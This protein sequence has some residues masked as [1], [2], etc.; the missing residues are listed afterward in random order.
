[1]IFSIIKPK[2]YSEKLRCVEATWRLIRLL[3]LKISYLGVKNKL[4]Q[5]PDYPSLLSIADCLEGFNINSLGIKSTFEK[6]N[7]LPA[8]FISVHEN[9]G[10][11]YYNLVYKMEDEKFT[12]WDNKSFKRITKTKEEFIS[13]WSGKILLVETSP[14]SK[15]PLSEYKHNTL[16]QWRSRSIIGASILLSFMLIISPL[17][18]F[19]WRLDINSVIYSFYY[20]LKF[21]GLLV[22]VLLLWH[23]I[24]NHNPFLQQLCTGAGEK[25]S[26]NSVLASKSAKLFG[27]ISWS[28]IGFA[29]FF[30]SVNTLI[31]F[32]LGE[33]HQVALM[34]ISVFGLLYI[35]YSIYFQYKVIK[36]WCPLCLAVQTTLFFEGLISIVLLSQKLNNPINILNKNSSSLFIIGLIF[37]ATLLIWNLI[38]DIIKAAKE[39]SFAKLSLSRI[40]NDADI[41]N[42]LLEKQAAHSELP[43]DLGIFIG[44]DQ[45]KH[46]IVK[47]CN[48]YCGPC[49]NMHVKLEKLMKEVKDIS[50]Q[51]IFNTPLNTKDKRYLPTKHLIAIAQTGISLYSLQQALDDWYTAP[52][53]DY[54]TFARNYPINNL[55]YE[56]IDVSIGLMSDWCSQNL[57]T[58]T[59]TLFIDGYKLPKSYSIDELSYILKG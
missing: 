41:F 49:A 20:F 58:A 17:L 52:I 39:S 30:A 42:A 3:K 57:I 4:E 18:S 29:Y 13:D 36:K 47:V 6:L 10:E 5:H 38:A 43:K 23:E 12:I 15:E 59:P 37:I 31:I 34:T 33:I 28:E 22:S 35:P 51:I 14:E 56:Q 45:A 7:T 44:D 53:K 32:G 55:D 21:F 48:P 40:K 24:D 50:V 27:V 25:S 16:L 1:M 11:E 46:R 54:E 2:Y 9:I 26:C 8:P 19:N